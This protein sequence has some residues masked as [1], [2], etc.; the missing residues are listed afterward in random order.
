MTNRDM[1]VTRSYTSDDALPL[2]RW[3]GLDPYDTPYLNWRTGAS[4]LIAFLVREKAMSVDFDTSV[5]EHGFVTYICEVYTDRGY[6]FDGCGATWYEALI[7][8][9]LQYCPEE[10]KAEVIPPVALG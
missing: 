3:M 6:Y 7:E 2:V 5:T 9:A 8:A 4:L 1:G 10:F